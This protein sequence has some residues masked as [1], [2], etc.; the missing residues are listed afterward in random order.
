MVIVI[1][2]EVVVIPSAV[3]VLELK[4]ERAQM[5][6]VEVVGVLE[7]CRPQ[8]GSHAHGVSPYSLF[9]PRVKGVREI[10]TIRRNTGLKRLISESLDL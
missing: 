5:M 8:R 1:A 9:R 4:F 2:P 6:I 3:V 7:F 10:S